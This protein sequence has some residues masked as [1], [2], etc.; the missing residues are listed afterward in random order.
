MH[1]CSHVKSEQHRK[2]KAVGQV[3]GAPC[4]IIFE[5]LFIPVS[6]RKH[7]RDL[8]G[9]CLSLEELSKQWGELSAWGAPMGAAIHRHVFAACESGAGWYFRTNSGHKIIA[10]EVLHGQSLLR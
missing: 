2:L 10:Y 9:C 1:G 6:R 8:Q 3:L 5:A 4:E 7:N